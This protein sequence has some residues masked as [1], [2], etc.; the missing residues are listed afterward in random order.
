MLGEIDTYVPHVFFF[1]GLGSEVERCRECIRYCDMSKGGPPVPTFPKRGI[2]LGIFPHAGLGGC[3]ADLEVPS[4][5]SKEVG[6]V[7]RVCMHAQTH[8]RTNARTH[9]H[10]HVV[11]RKY[12]KLSVPTYLGGRTLYLG[13]ECTVGRPPDGR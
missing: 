12:R 2:E 10:T 8:V 7:R 4:P 6:R 3:N 1:L 13:R 11:A 9:E 5:R